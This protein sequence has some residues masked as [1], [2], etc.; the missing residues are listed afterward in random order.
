[1]PY[2]IGGGYGVRLGDPDTDETEECRGAGEPWCEGLYV[3]GGDGYDGWCPNCADRQFA[4]YDADCHGASADLTAGPAASAASGPR[5]SADRDCGLGAMLPG[6]QSA[7][8]TG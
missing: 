5:P 6:P 7:G 2:V 4:D 1:M 3:A 8:T